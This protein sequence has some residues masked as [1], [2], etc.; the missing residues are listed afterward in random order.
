MGFK[1]FT[2]NEI[3]QFK[4]DHIKWLDCK[5][6]LDNIT[7]RQKQF[8]RKVLNHLKPILDKF[9]MFS[10]TYYEYE[11][12]S[13]SVIVRVFNGAYKSL[14]LMIFLENLPKIKNYDDL[15]KNSAKI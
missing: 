2:D 5:H 3:E 8:E 9:K 6:E 11:I 4:N 14:T 12:T 13:H 7:K 15:I 1:M 10:D